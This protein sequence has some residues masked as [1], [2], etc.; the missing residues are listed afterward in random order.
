MTHDSPSEPEGRIAVDRTAMRVL[1]INDRGEVLLLQGFEPTHPDQLSGSASVA[2]S[3]PA[4]TI[5]RLRFAKW[6]KKNRHHGDDAEPARP[7]YPRDRRVQL[8]QLRRHAASDVVG[9]EG[10][11]SERQLRRPGRDRAIHHCRTSMVDTRRPSEWWTDLRIR[12]VEQM[13]TLAAGG[14]IA[15]SMRSL[16]SFTFIPRVRVDY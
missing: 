14:L 4:R 9:C 12:L 13:R 5:A 3:R 1:P 15:A 16:A 6:P 10:R 11:R 8:G 2:G 7:V